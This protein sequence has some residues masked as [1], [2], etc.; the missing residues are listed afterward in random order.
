M[1]S[2]R[3]I[4]RVITRLASEALNLKILLPLLKVISLRGAFPVVCSQKF[5]LQVAS[6]IAMLWSAHEGR[7]C[8]SWRAL[9]EVTL[10]AC[11]LGKATIASD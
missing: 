9:S 5:M 2:K 11:A 3:I 7:R 1:K 10:I 6:L 4:I 8:L